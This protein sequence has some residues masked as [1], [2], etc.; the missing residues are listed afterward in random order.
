M[1]L[2]HYISM[3]LRAG[4][5]IILVAF[6]QNIGHYSSVQRRFGTQRCA[7]STPPPLLSL[8][9]FL[10][11]ATPLP[12]ELLL[13]SSSTATILPMPPKPTISLLGSLLLSFLSSLYSYST[14]VDIS[15]DLSLSLSPPHPPPLPPC[16][17]LSHPLPPPSPSLSPPPLPSNPALIKTSTPKSQN[18]HRSLASEIESGSVVH[19]DAFTHTHESDDH[20]NSPRSAATAAARPP[21]AP[22]FSMGDGAAELTR[23]IR[24]AVKVLRGRSGGSA[25]LLILVS[26]WDF[27]CLVSL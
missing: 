2:H 22:L 6:E 13:S 11:P 24:D 19:I 4:S 5:G 17:P 15:L 7:A 16:L 26:V 10:S 3:H 9:L 1:L 25:P 18:A 27:R 20:C 8:S 23:R 12:A 21:P 14:Q